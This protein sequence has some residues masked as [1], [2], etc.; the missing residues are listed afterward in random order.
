VNRYFYVPDDQP[1]GVPGAFT[2][3]AKEAVSTLGKD[4]R[5][6]KPVDV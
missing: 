6:R 2:V 4:L 5:F 3:P 1:S